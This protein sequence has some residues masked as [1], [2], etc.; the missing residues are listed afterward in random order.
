MPTIRRA[1]YYAL[2]TLARRTGDQNINAADVTDRRQTGLTLLALIRRVQ[3]LESLVRAPITVALTP[4]LLPFGGLAQW[5]AISWG[6]VTTEGVRLGTYV[7][8]LREADQAGGILPISLPNGVRL[9]QLKVLGEQTDAGNMQTSLIQEARTEPFTEATLVTIRG[10]GGVATA[11][12][13]I[14]GTPKFDAAANPLPARRGLNAAPGS[15]ALPR[16]STHIP[17]LGRWMR[18]WSGPEVT[19]AVDARGYARYADDL[20]VLVD[21]YGRHACG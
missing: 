15:D 14:P 18:C 11:P 5:S 2:A 19:R 1:R 9:T 16:L 13:P 7:E 4:I 6:R 17:A 10:F 12:T 20:V 8:K 21:G 3:Q